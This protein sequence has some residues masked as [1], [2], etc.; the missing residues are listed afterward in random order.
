MDR[1]RVCLAALVAAP[2][3]AIAGGAVMAWGLLPGS[4]PADVLS[5][6][7]TLGAATVAGILAERLL[8]A[9]LAPRSEP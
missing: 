9:E 4:D 7:V 1:C 8:A 2:W 6:E 3:L 5:G